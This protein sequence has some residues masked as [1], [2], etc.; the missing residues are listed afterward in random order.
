MKFGLL[1]GE[2]LRNSGR[3]AGTVLISLVGLCL[4]VLVGTWWP[5]KFSQAQYLIGNFLGLLPSALLGLLSA[6][7]QTLFLVICVVKSAGG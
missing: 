1:E 3:G 5:L 7:P 6:A 4:V 2:G